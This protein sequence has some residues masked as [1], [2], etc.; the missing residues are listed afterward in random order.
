LR[1]KTKQLKIIYFHTRIPSNLESAFNGR[2][3]LK[4]LI[5]RNAGISATPRKSRTVP[6]TLTTTITKSNQFQAVVK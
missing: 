3:A 6:K 2:N 5:D 1:T 4:V